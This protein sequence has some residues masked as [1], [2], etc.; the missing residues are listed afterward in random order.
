MPDLFLEPI[1]EKNAQNQPTGVVTDPAADITAFL[2]S[3]Q[4]KIGSRG[5]ASGQNDWT[6]WQTA[7]AFADLA[8][9]SGSRATPFRRDA[10]RQIPRAVGFAEI[11]TGEAEDQRAGAH[12]AEPTRIAS[13]RQLEFVGRSTISKYGCFGCHDIPGFED[14]KPIGTGSADW[15]RK[16]TSKL[17]FEN[18]HKFLETHGINQENPTH[19]AQAEVAARECR[20]DGDDA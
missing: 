11:A 16:E 12:R 6:S 5:R 19:D 2:L 15:G 13:I 20:E 7:N 9:S 18:I 17:A 4:N 14:A 3:V 8:D 1:V 10:A